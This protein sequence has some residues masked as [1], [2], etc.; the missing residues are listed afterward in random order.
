MSVINLTSFPGTTINFYDVTRTWQ[1]TWGAIYLHMSQDIPN[2]PY[3]T[4]T[5]TQWYYGPVPTSMYISVDADILLYFSIIYNFPDS[6]G[7]N[8]NYNVVLRIYHIEGYYEYYSIDLSTGSR[9]ILGSGTVSNPNGTVVSTTVTI[10]SNQAFG[11]T[12]KRTSSYPRPRFGFSVY[13][14]I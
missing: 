14:N 9:S 10:S 11:I 3:R 2:Y 6:L 4:Y 13:T 5:P 1:M 8:V 7:Y 12:Y